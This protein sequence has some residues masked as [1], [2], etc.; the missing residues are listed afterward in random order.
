MT[1]IAR[2]AGY[3]GCARPLSPWM[4][5]PITGRVC[6]TQSLPSGRKKV[7][8]P[9]MPIREDVIGTGPP[10]DDIDPELSRR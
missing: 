2:G 3:Q 6:N 4:S 1:Y 5:A 10:S 9:Q 7:G 8:I